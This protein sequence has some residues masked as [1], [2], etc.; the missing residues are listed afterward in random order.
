MKL[1]AGLWFYLFYKPERTK[2]LKPNNTENKTSIV[3]AN[4][5]DT[6]GEK[7]KVNGNLGVCLD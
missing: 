5:L 2:G 7:V 3:H 4:N 6:R 1:L